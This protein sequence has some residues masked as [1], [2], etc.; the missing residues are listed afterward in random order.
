MSFIGRANW[1]CPTTANDLT[2]RGVPDV[3]TYTVCGLSPGW[4]RQLSGKAVE[5]PDDAD[6]LANEQ[7]DGIRGQSRQ[8]LTIRA[9]ILLLCKVSCLRE[10]GELEYDNTLR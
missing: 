6:A 3:P 7:P 1:D 4:K 8:A 9:W 10:N 2:G 5:A